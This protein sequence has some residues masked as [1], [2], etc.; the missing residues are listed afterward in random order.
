MPI[1]VIPESA[2]F[3]PAQRAWLNGFFAGVLG[4][5]QGARGDA[6]APRPSAP[7]DDED[8]PWHDPALSLEERMALAAERPLPRR[9]MAA[10]GQLDCGQCGHLCKTYAELIADG[11]EKDLTKCVP[12]GKATARKLKALVARYPVAAQDSGGSSAAAKP[13]VQSV[14]P[15]EVRPGASRDRPLLATL[16]R[17]EPLNQA[18][19]EKQIQNVVLSL[20]DSGLV[21]EPGDSLGVWALNYP[22]EVDLVLTILR[23]RG[24]EQVTLADGS[25]LAAREALTRKCNLREPGEE[26]YRLMSRHAQNDIEA[27]RLAQLAEDD[28]AAAQYGVHDVFDVLTKFR[29]ARPP[30]SEFAAALDPLQPRLYSIASSLK[31]HPGEVHLTVAVVRYALYRRDYGGVASNFFAERLRP[32]Q[33]VPIFIQRSR[34][35]KLPADPGAPVIMIGPGTGVAPF[36]AFLQER[37]AAHATGRNWLVFGN[38]R[39]ELDFL[40]REEFE[41]YLRDGLLTSLHTAFSRDQRDKIY[42]QHRISEHAPEIWKWLEEGAHFYVCGDAK[43]MARDVDLTLRQIVAEQG[44]MPGERAAAYVASLAKSNRYQRDVY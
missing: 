10:M 32:G 36:R 35:F 17:S 26:L 6:A 37:A 19:A 33:R 7:A 24:S 20:G 42:V 14:P 22:E 38:Q 34:G 15:A 9:L 44:R 40:Y 31:R 1:A 2:P 12:G 39:R 13:C 43:R 18:G 28:G 30:I 5:D 25:K 8:F 27:T 41:S 11:G 16:V 4:L 23:A 29:S 3:T 21:Y